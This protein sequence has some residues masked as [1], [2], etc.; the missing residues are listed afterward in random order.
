MVTKSGSKAQDRWFEPRLDP[1]N[2][3]AWLLYKCV[4]LRRSAYG[5]SATVA[6]LGTFCGEKEISSWLWKN[7]LSC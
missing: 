1:H 3:L 7:D 6:P 4:A 5:A 2:K